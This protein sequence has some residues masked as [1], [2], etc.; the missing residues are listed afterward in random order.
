LSSHRFSTE[1]RLIELLVAVKHSF[2]RART[3]LATPQVGF[4]AL[5][6]RIFAMIEISF[7]ML[8]AVQA[9]NHSVRT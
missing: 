2:F 3:V 8:N 1:T 7:F 9:Y 6:A 4:N 5:S